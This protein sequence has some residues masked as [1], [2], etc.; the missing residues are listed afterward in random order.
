MRFGRVRIENGLK[1][2]MGIGEKNGLEKLRFKEHS[3][4][5]F[6]ERGGQKDDV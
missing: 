3:N 6:F 5:P 2:T 4:T 1:R